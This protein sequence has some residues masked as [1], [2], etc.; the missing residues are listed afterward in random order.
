M[1]SWW[2]RTGMEIGFRFI[3]GFILSLSGGFKYYDDQNH[4]VPAL[5]GLYAGLTAQINFGTGVETGTLEAALAQDEPVFPALLSLYR[6]NP[7]GA[8]RISNRESAEVRN[9]K[10][11]F[12]AG[13]YTSSEYECG[14]LSFIP[15]GRSVEIPLYA[16]FSPALLN[17]TDDGRILGELVIRYMLL[18]R[19]RTLVRTLAVQVYNRN[20]F[21]WADP[22]VLGAF[23]SPRSREIMEYSKYI[24]GLA[25]S[26]LR[27]GINRNMQFGIYLFEGLRGMGLHRGGPGD[28]PYE[29]HHAEIGQLD[30]VQFPFQT[31]SY[32]TGDVD[33]L[34]ILY[35]ASLEAAGLRSSFIAL[36]KDFIVLLPLGI[37]E[38]A[39]NSFFSNTERVLIVNDELMLPLSMAAF[40]EGFTTAWNRAMETLAEA[41][42]SS[43]TEIDLIAPEDC[44]L[45]YPPANLPPRELRFNPPQT[46]ALTAAADEA[47]MQY[48]SAELEPKAAALRQEL[49][50]APTAV[51]YN[52]LGTAYVRSGL[53]N[54]ARAAFTNAAERN[55]A[56]AMVNLGN[57][58]ALDRDWAAAEQW[59][60]RALELSPDSSAARQGLEQSLEA[61]E[62]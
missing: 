5:S 58:Y 23:I 40:D 19:E 53:L 30:T 36:E 32:L 25:R 4:E 49:G 7:V 43:A 29:K 1:A 12:R 31:I 18:G 10:V 26:R 46:A 14:T 20:S 24:T 54:E 11:S 2:G 48:I 21:R 8:V 61:R 39:A 52:Q 6:Q 22:G 33:D 27:T 62:D 56:A 35:A 15:R 44:W 55:S 28:T 17:F 57:L 59:Y 3:P 34:G 9:L 51:L 60:R 13:S 38:A 47:L 41:F 50:R 45:V 42:A 16:D 37:N